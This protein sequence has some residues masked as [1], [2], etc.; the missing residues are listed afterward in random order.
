MALS[1]QATALGL[2]LAL[3]ASADVRAEV[4]DPVRITHEQYRRLNGLACA[5]CG[6]TDALRPGGMAHT[7]SGTDGSGRLAWPVMVCRHHASTGGT[8]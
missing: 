8:W 1:V 5:R 7:R 4:L 3:P 2:P 6:G